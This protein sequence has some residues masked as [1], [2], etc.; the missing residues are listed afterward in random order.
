MIVAEIVEKASCKK[1]LQARLHDITTRMD[2]L[3]INRER[4]QRTKHAHLLSCTMHQI[5]HVSKT[6]NALA[7]ALLQDDNRKLQGGKGD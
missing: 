4:L 3:Q 6:L 1:N 7:L 5:D 2:E